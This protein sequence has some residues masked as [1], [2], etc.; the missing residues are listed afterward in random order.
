M[1]ARVLEQIDTIPSSDT[2]ARKALPVDGHQRVARLL[3][4]QSP[5]C[6]HRRETDWQERW[7]ATLFQIKRE[8]DPLLIGIPLGTARSIIRR[9]LATR[10]RSPT[11]D[12]MIQWCERSAPYSTE[13][14][15]WIVN[16]RPVAYRPSEL[17]P[18]SAPTTA[19]TG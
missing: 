8:E 11:G 17:K 14:V 16:I 15:G 6:A 19:L 4:G 7:Q 12:V 2:N 1:N 5:A 9:V 13:Q 10:P 3:F 18:V